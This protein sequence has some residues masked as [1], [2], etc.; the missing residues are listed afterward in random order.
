L[1][2]SRNSGIRA[3]IAKAIRVKKEENTMENILRKRPIPEYYDTM[4]MDGYEPWEIMEAVHKRMRRIV[5]EREAEDNSV[6][7]VK[8]TSVIKKR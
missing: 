8:I 6:S 1:L 7:E 4:Y 5:A 3:K 2:R